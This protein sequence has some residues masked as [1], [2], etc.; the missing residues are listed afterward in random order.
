MQALWRLE[1]ARALRGIDAPGDL[2]EMARM[3]LYELG[4][5]AAVW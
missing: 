4:G 5:L 3:A 1:L 2:P